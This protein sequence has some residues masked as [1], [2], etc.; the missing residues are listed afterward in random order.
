MI[1][2]TQRSLGGVAAVR[3]RVVEVLANIYPECS[4]P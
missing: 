4:Y 3:L 2:A 1:K